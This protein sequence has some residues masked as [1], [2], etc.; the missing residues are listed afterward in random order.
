MNFLEIVQAEIDVS[1]THLQLCMPEDTLEPEDIP[2]TLDVGK[3]KR[4]TQCMEGAANTCYTEPLAYLLEVSKCIA[5]FEWFSC[6]RKEK[7]VAVL[8]PVLL[9]ELKQEPP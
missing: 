4:M 6:I 8:R 9:C 5:L 7:E 3:S 2:T 1:A